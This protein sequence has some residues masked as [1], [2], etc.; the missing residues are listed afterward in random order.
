[1]PLS[2]LDYQIIKLPKY[3][4]ETAIAARALCSLVSVLA[5][6]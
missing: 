3:N 6:M 1:M 5:T 4:L 2:Q